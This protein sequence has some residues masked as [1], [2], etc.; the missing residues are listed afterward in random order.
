ML[1]CYGSFLGLR[2][3]VA[4][5]AEEVTAVEII[6]TAVNENEE[7]R[8]NQQQQRAEQPPNA[9]TGNNLTSDH[10]FLSR[11]FR[12]LLLRFIFTPLNFTYILFTALF[13]CIAN[14]RKTVAIIFISFLVLVPSLSIY[15]ALHHHS[16]SSQVETRVSNF[17]VSQFDIRDNYLSYN[18]TF[19]LDVF[20]L[21]KSN[22]IDIESNVN[23]LFTQKLIGSTYISPFSLNT[24]E[25]KHFTIH[26]SK[27]LHFQPKNNVFDKK[28]FLYLLI[29]SSIT[30]YSNLEPQ[31]VSTSQLQ[32]KCNFLATKD[33][34]GFVLSWEYC[35]SVMK[36]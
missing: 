30:T 13:Y 26:L 2:T 33:L 29:K 9:G 34:N 16:N 24:S 12:F 22:L 36:L 7:I 21:Y 8:P 17:N 31:K 5:P 27:K 19:S 6:P 3:L 14:Q 32:V 25:S 11:L 15:F 1:Y 28:L 10:T 20:N 23:L 4:D 18:I 35:Q